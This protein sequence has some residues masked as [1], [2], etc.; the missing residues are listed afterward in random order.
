MFKVDFY[1]YHVRY[2]SADS[3]LRNDDQ[4]IKKNGI[5]VVKFISIPKSDCT[6]HVL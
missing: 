6:Y 5:V 3:V 2:T 4:T 1:F